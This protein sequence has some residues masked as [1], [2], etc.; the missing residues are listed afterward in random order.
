MRII[1]KQY[2]NGIFQWIKCTSQTEKSTSP[3][4]K[5]MDRTF[6][7]CCKVKEN[8]LKTWCKL[9]IMLLFFNF[10]FK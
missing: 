3:Q 8:D 5:I 2:Q 1:F 4:D 7:T 9:L 6:F 10:C